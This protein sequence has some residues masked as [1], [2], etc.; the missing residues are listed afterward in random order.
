MHLKN[1]SSIRFGAFTNL[2]QNL[3]AKETI[4]NET[5]G[6]D[7]NGGLVRIDSVSVREDIPGKVVIPATYCAGV[8][9]HSS[10]N[11]WLVG[12]DF[13]TTNWTNYRYMGDKD[14]TNKTWT[15]HVGAEYYPVKANAA[16]N[17]Y[18]NYIKYRAGFFYGPDYIKISQTRNNY[19]ATLGA[20]FPLTTPRYIQSRGEYVA[21]NTS[22]EI[23]GRG[24][25][26]TAIIREN[27]IRFN[28]GISM[29]ARWFQKRS[30]E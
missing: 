7:G 9:Y 17:K 13:E 22:C 27:T 2:Q 26:Q 12:A 10:N 14:L 24:N 4:I 16:N 8:L 23:G 15:V 28:I 21:L 1:G 29:N 25:K 19:A 20:S 5:F 11:N 30:Y 6:Y 3:K 18:L